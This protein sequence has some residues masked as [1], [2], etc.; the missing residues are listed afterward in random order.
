M[1]SVG[2]DVSKGKS[3]ACAIKPYGEI[4]ASPFEF[5]HTESDL[6]S[7]CDMFSR[8]DDEVRV[9]MEATSIYHLPVATYL[10]E[11]GM[12]ISVVNPYEMKQYRTR[13]LR[14]VKTDRTDSMMIAGYGID[15]WYSLKEFQVSQDIYA[16][17]KILSSQYRHHMQLRISALLGLTHLLDYTM[18]G[19]KRELKSWNEDNGK[20]KLG[21]FVDKYWH[22]DNITK[23][24][25][26]KFIDHY[27]KWAEKKGYHQ[28]QSKAAKI[29]SMAKE[30]IPTLP[31]NQTTQMLVH[32]AVEVLKRVDETLNTILA[33]MKEL[34]KSL[35]EY[36][37]VRAMGGVGDTL[38]PRLIAD[39]GDVRR[40]HN[41]K[42][43]IAFAGIDAPPYQSGQFIGT[44]R[45]IS[46]RGSSAIRKTGYEVMRSLKSHREPEDSS[47]YHFILKKEAEGKPKKVAKMAGLNKFLRIY[48]ARVQEVYNE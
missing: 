5:Q 16:E 24:S 39:I 13:G 47:V 4:I 6:K 3:T 14:K 19:I 43:L 30:G 40:F 27:C 36:P 15:Y 2:I 11:Q 10:I 20:D 28:N 26:S 29:Y 7:L 21:D 12:F 22:Y 31:A 1:I 23:M 41:S 8:M 46:K 32:E 17:L 35:P 37:V 18:P 9:V 38:A 48:Y 42:A 44:E 45:H 25:E 33:R 34:A